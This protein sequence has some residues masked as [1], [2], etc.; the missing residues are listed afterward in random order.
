M[1]RGKSTKPFVAIAIDFPEHPKVTEL[2][3][4]AFRFHVTA[5]A[6]CAR[7]LT[8]GHVSARGVKVVAA[9]VDTQPKRWTAELVAARLW[10]HDPAGDGF[11]IHNYLEYNPSQEEVKERSERGRR[12]ANSR[13]TGNADGNA[14]GI[15]GGIGKA[16][17]LPSHPI[18]LNEI[19]APPSYEGTD[20]TPLGKL[21][22]AC[23]VDHDGVV[24]LNRAAKGCT[25]ADLVAA[26][27]ACKGPG[28]RDRLAVALSELK[29]RREVA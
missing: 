16:N 22:A 18:P 15:G 12:N 28:V 23:R 6:Y 1:K 27:E 11:W 7:N 24:K 25:E 14:T 10:R 26:L 4:R 19:Q 13:W 20:F 9:I 5:L 2:H 3:D 29:K 17:A 21:K 8:D